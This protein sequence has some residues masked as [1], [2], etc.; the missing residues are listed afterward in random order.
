MLFASL[1]VL[2]GDFWDKVRSL[3]VHG[4]TARFPGAAG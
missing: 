1:F 2:G 3:F 4:A